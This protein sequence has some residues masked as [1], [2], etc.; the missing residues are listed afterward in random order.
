MPPLPENPDTGLPTFFTDGNRDVKMAE[1]TPR[2]SLRER[3]SQHLFSRRG[4]PTFERKRKN[5]KEI[6]RR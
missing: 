4:F 3:F 2:G 6:P 1:Y 5:K